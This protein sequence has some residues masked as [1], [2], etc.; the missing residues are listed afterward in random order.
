MATPQKMALNL[1]KPV[2]RDNKQPL[3]GLEK[4]G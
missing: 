2:F 1:Q 3:N 4:L